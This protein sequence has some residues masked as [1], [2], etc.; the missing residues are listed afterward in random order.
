VIAIARFT[1]ANMS[2][3]SGVLLGIILV[4]SSF[5]IT[6]FSP[7]AVDRML[8]RTKAAPRFAEHCPKAEKIRIQL[9]LQFEMTHYQLFQDRRF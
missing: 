6:Y 2:S 5:A 1:L 7:V 4:R 9:A 3:D 8:R